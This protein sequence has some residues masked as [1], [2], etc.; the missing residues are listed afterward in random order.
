MSRLLNVFVD[1]FSDD[2]VSVVRNTLVA[3]AGLAG[4]GVT[5]ARLI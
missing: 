3:I 2:P 4:V 1:F 5:V